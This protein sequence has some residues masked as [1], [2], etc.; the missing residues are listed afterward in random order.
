MLR[1]KTHASK[2]QGRQ[3]AV[4]H[5]FTWRV[6]LTGVQNPHCDAWPSANW[7]WIG[8]SCPGG[9]SAPQPSAPCATPSIVVTWQ[10]CA[11]ASGVRQ[12][13]TGRCLPPTP[14][15]VSMT[16]HAPQPPALQPT[17]VPVRWISR[18]RKSTSICGS[19]ELYGT[20]WCSPLTTMRNVSISSKELARLLPLQETARS[21]LCYI[22]SAATDTKRP[23]ASKS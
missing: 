21:R 23:A 4:Q 8:C 22:Y 7:R 1:F 14:G 12:L 10:L 20:R 15:S 2:A 13:R 18:R 17:L 5:S 6:S 19:D 9:E 3:Y 16:V 11:S